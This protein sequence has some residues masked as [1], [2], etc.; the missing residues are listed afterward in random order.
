VWEV[1]GGSAGGGAHHGLPA[2]RRGGHKAKA[3]EAART[4]RATDCQRLMAD[5][6]FDSRFITTTRR[7]SRRLIKPRHRRLHVPLG[8]CAR[9][10]GNLSGNLIPYSLA[11]KQL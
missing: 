11:G 9:G 6:H 8:E 1:G 3:Q 2:D 4:R 10:F 7:S 5:R